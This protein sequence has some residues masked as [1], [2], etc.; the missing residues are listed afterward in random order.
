[1]GLVSLCDSLKDEARAV[2]LFRIAA[3]EGD[4]EGQFNLGLMLSE[5]RGTTRK[6]EVEAAVWYRFLRRN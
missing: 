3:K 4:L 5:G 2:E 1:M 6:D